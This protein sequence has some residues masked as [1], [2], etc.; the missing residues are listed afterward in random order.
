MRDIFSIFETV[1]KEKGLSFRLANLQTGLYKKQNAMSKNCS[2]L[3]RWD[4]YIRL[5]T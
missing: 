1:K 2:H 5:I 3:G 4:L